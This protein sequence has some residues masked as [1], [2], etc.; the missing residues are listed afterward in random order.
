MSKDLAVLDGLDERQ[1]SFLDYL[2]GEAKGD[3]IKAKKLAGYSDNY[4]TTKLIS[5]LKEHI[6]RVAEEM[7]AANAIKAVVGLSDVIDQPGVLGA[8]NKVSAAK[9][10][11]DRAGLAK[12]EQ[13][14]INVKIEGILILPAKEPVKI[15]DGTFSKVEQES[16]PYHSE[17]VDIDLNSSYTP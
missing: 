13:K 1:R 10:I 11:L 5:S 14:D 2:S 12:K 16:L 3:I 9:E 7:L 6:I 8:A 15:I 17:S 4:R